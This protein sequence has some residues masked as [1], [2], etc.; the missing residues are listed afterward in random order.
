MNKAF[1]KKIS[2]DDNFELLTYIKKE[3]NR[4]HFFKDFFKILKKICE[5]LIL[6]QE[7]C[8]FV[9]YDFHLS[10]ILLEYEYDENDILLKYNIKIIDFSKSSI[11]VY[12][13][14]RQY[15]LKYINIRDEKNPYFFIPLYS[16]SWYI[17]D[18]LMLIN[19]FVLHY[20]DYGIY[21]TN[22]TQKIIEI[23]NFNVNCLEIANNEIKLL[24]KTNKYRNMNMSKFSVLLINNIELR[25]KIYGKNANYIL[26]D[27]RNLREKIIEL[28]L[29]E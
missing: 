21:I 11:I 16:H 10:N 7:K 4:I 14:N 13:H 12:K 22:I 28:K 24:N 18:M 20:K 27:P 8:C 6:F 2:K 5:I 29:T 25:K 17:I 23:F 15:L 3:H 1:D 9:H 26:Y 19:R